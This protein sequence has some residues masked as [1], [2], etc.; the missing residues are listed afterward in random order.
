MEGDAQTLEAILKEKIAVKPYK[1]YE[2]ELVTKPITF[3]HPD[4]VEDESKATEATASV[5]A[6][7]VEAE[8]VE[9]ADTTVEE[10]A[11]ESAD[12]SEDKHE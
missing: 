2:K 11:D 9:P 8:P 3:V 10:P 1:K 6:E 5:E 4:I 7:S 12:K